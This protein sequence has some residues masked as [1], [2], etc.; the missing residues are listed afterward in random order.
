MII[1]DIIENGDA[2]TK[3]VKR[4]K[5]MLDYFGNCHIFNTTDDR[6]DK[7]IIIISGVKYSLSLR[8]YCYFTDNRATKLTDLSYGDC[9]PNQWDHIL[10]CLPAPTKHKKNQKEVYEDRGNYRDNDTQ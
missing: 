2:R 5:K 10:S 4:C 8:D 3:Q 6:K 1:I 7:T 9:D